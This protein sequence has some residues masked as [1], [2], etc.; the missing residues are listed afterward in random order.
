MKSNI[1]PVLR[2]IVVL[3]LPGALLCGQDLDSLVHE[4]IKN[5]PGLKAYQL[6]N[7][8]QEK[9]ISVAEAWPA[10]TVGIEFSQIKAG[11]F[12]I[13]ND[14]M[15]NNLIASQMFPLGGKT[16]A[17]ADA[18]KKA[19]DVQLSNYDEAVCD[20]IAKIKMSYAGLWATQ[21]K[22]DLQKRTAA[23]INALIKN[24]EQSLTARGAVQADIVLLQSELALNE[25]EQ[26]AL[27]R[28]FISQ[29]YEL[30]KLLGRPLENSAPPLPA[31]LPLEEPEDS[32]EDIIAALAE[33]NPALRK[34]DGMI[35]MNRAMITANNK[36]MIPDLMVQGMFMRMPMGMPITSI[37]IN[38]HGSTSVEAMT[39]YAYSLM[40]SVNLPF[41]P[42]SAAKIDKR[43][44]ELAAG[45]EAIE[46]E[47]KE[48]ERDMAATVRKLMNKYRS[49]VEQEEL[50]LNKTL[51]AY[52]LAAELQ[53]NELLTGRGNVASVLSVYRMQLMQEMNAVM[54]RMDA[55]MSAAELE[56][57]TGLSV[58]H[59]E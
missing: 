8:A 25:T 45:I 18:E 4:A 32:A 56:M 14:A 22:I 3:F 53:T 23:L 16:T 27:S 49:A 34:M 1:M 17:M 10:P 11:K 19:L 2:L 33:E 40:F 48:M 21:R 26:S 43:S 57:M 46:Y 12:N 13:I 31:V 41:A 39:E 29:T 5:N 59:G 36:E 6:K 38:P 9:K 55:A 15:S 50:Y 24:Y 37:T 44:E 54:A 30:N 58:H 20:L 47:K 51:P 28:E 52:K 7:K 42:W 35:A